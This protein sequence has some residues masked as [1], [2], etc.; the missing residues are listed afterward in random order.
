[1]PRTCKTPP[2]ETGGASRDCCGGPSHFLSNPVALQAQIL[3]PAHHVRPELAVMLAAL[4]F[5]GQGR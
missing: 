2:W 5:E 4:A 1:M 3:I